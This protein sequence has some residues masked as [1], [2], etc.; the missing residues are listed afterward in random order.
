MAPGGERRQ[1]LVAMWQEADVHQQLAEEL[2]TLRPWPGVNA[3]VDERRRAVGE[4][5]QTLTAGRF[6]EPRHGRR[7][8]MTARSS[9]SSQRAPTARWTGLDPVRDLPLNS[10]DAPVRS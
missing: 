7:G 2:P 5:G 9:L 1:V 4:R 6:A 8:P 3:L 10:L